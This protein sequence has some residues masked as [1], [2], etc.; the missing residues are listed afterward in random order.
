VHPE[1]DH[2]THA[3]PE[4]YLTAAIAGI[5]GVIK[6]RP[7]DFIVEEIPAYD[8]TGEG[9][10]IY[11]FIQKV[12][13]STSQLVSILA[14][15]FGVRESAVGY[16]GLKDR[17]AITRQVVSIHTPGK[18]PEDFPALRDG[19][20][21]VLWSDLHANKLRRGHLKANR[22]SIKVREV[23]LRA[24]FDA[25]K[26]L[27]A[28]ALSGVPNRTGEQRF[29]ILANNHLV[30]RAIILGDDQSAL[31]ILLGPLPPGTEDLSDAN[32]Q[33]RRLYAEK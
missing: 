28:L 8:P 29:G 4:A 20:I 33:S 30:G 12:G 3:R 17:H 27:D 10:H 18:K 31:D 16:A 22:F 19:R 11:L 6:Q 25:K 21:Q 32:R 15:H 23:P 26:T 7:E 13:L 2:S 5:G 14:R 24:V 9:E 1:A